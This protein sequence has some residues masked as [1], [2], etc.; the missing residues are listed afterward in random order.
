M[1]KAKGRAA[2]QFIWNLVLS[3]L[4]GHMFSPGLQG[5][6]VQPAL[7]DM[8]SMSCY[9]PLAEGGPHEWFFNSQLIHNNT[10][11]PVKSTEMKT[12]ETI[13]LK[14]LGWWQG[15]SGFRETTCFLSYM[16]SDH[17][18]GV[19]LLMVLLWGES[20]SDLPGSSHA[21]PASS[22]PSTESDLAL[23]IWHP[24]SQMDP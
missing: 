3:S 1:S 20:W 24:V 7:G 11:G 9:I 10:A 15:C 4:T 23:K 8:R 19:L 6:I 12:C 14:L 13:K 21:D 22:C 17:A 5:Q 18:L 2:V 16:F